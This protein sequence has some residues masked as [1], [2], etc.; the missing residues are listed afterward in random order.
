MLR[1]LSSAI[2]NIAGK[3]RNASLPRR[4]VVKFKRC[5]I[6]IGTEKTGSSTIQKFLALNRKRFAREGI[7]YPAATG[8]DGGSQWGFAASARPD[9][10]K[11]DIGL[12]LSISTE[13][14]LAQ[15]KETFQAKLDKET[16]HIGNPDTLIISA[17]HLQSRLVNQTFI[18]NLKTFLEKWA[19]TFEIIVYF[20]RQDRVA[21]S[22]YSTTIKSG[23]ENQQVF[24][25]M[26][27]NGLSYYFDYEKI[28]D[29]WSAI[30]GKT[31]IKVRLFSPSELHQGDLIAD[32][33]FAAGLNHEGKTLPEKQENASL[34]RE[35]TQFLQEINRQI[36]NLIDGKRNME[37]DLLVQS[38]S[39]L[40]PG[41]YRP[42]TRKQALSFYQQFTDG[43][44]RLC[45]QVFPERKAPLF[46]DDFS[47]Y[48]EHAENQEP[49]YAE[50]VAIAIRLWREIGASN[51]EAGLRITKLPQTVDEVS[52]TNA[53]PE[54]IT[55]V[56]Q[57]AKSSDGVK[58]QPPEQTPA[59][60]PAK[61]PVMGVVSPLV[62]VVM[63]S[64]NQK[65]FITA[66]IDSILN[67]SHERIE[68]IVA[69]GASNDGTQDIL[70]ERA[71]HD[72]RL[73]W[74]S[75]PDSGPAEALNKALAKTRGTLIGW[76][77][78]DDLYTAGAI[79]RA[80]QAFH[81]NPDWIMAYGRGEHIDVNAKVMNAY[82]TLKPQGS[83]SRFA[84]G[85][86]ICQPT[87]FFKKS[88]YNLLGP[89]DAD[90]KASFDFEYWLRAFTDFPERIGFI[91]TMQAQSRLHDACITKTQRGLV[92]VESIRVIALHLGVSPI[93]WFSTYVEEFLALPAGQRQGQSVRDHLLDIIGTV[94]NDLEP[95]DV[96][97]AKK[98]VENLG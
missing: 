38:I 52:R 22:F 92:A 32:F 70:A 27:K 21:V 34:V 36:P 15:Y 1:A 54:D 64:Y 78:S 47:D 17:E 94:E 96:T 57:G 53:I 85:C 29:N 90:L 2:Y 51:A 30:F 39:S 45:M 71:S 58:S 43:N 73:K 40:Y 6:H 11:M 82:P 41:Q 63:P 59:P 49:R 65:E 87:V 9:A 69:D 93:H 48:Q 77:N 46:D 10:W 97:A 23:R 8:K 98:I 80:V 19:E 50:A 13:A 20:R 4:D 44:N 55:P 16:R 67:Q 84:S 18:A 68:L 26:P 35:A 5:V 12:F 62:S 81:H 14:E 95:N 88:M 25:P 83:I 61:A 60:A 56:K 42:T 76:L 66:S 3:I 28:Y 86:F 37:R 79:A 33:C 31:N 72:P 75:E 91:D 24:P 7:L 89:L 74:F